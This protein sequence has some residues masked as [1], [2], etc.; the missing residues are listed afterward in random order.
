MA[1]RSDPSAF[2]PGSALPRTPARPGRERRY[3]RPALHPSGRESAVAASSSGRDGREPEWRP[4]RPLRRIVGDLHPALERFVSRLQDLDDAEAR[5]A[6]VDR[7]PSGVYTVEKV[8]RL[9]L[10]GLGLLDSRS[11]HISAPVADQEPVQ[12]L[13]SS[14]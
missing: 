2:A 3:S 11:P 12:P 13:V 6:V 9:E 5:I 4:L 7:G 14:D 8:P 10:Q 1:G